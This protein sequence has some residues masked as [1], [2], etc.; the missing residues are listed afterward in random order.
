MYAVSDNGY[1]FGFGCK[2]YALAHMSKDTELL[3]TV[4]VEKS[5]TGTYFGWLETNENGNTE[6]TYTL[7]RHGSEAFNMQFAYGYLI[8]QLSGKGM[9]VRLSV[10]VES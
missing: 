7:I 10:T 2:E 9:R 3:V 8:E 5:N 4:K 1:L 6:E